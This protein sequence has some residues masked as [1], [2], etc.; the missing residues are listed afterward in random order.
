MFLFFV[1]LL[2]ALRAREDDDDDDNDKDDADDKVSEDTHEVLIQ[3][4]EEQRAAAIGISGVQGGDGEAL[5]LD[6]L[7][8]SIAFRDVAGNPIIPLTNVPITEY[9]DIILPK[10]Q[11]ININYMTG[12]MQFM[13]TETIDVTPF[14]YFDLSLITI[15]DW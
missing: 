2:R 15:Y 8:N 11:I 10:L 5:V 3:L 13:T 1:A 7:S 12:L 9:P 6:I 4:Q 14:T